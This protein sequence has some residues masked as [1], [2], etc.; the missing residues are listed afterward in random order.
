M[1][2]P[3]PSRD[4]SPSEAS[5]S[6]AGQPGRNTARRV[7]DQILS[8]TFGQA[9]SDQTSLEAFAPVAQRLGHQPFGL[10]PVV[11]ELVG[12]AIQRTFPK[13][14]FESPTGREMIRDVAQSLYADPRS[15]ERLKQIWSRLLE[16]LGGP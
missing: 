6:A 11:E 5:P 1:T 4:D 13:M 10:T 9:S 15:V 14:T 16:Q 2:Q 12:C 3:S 8:Q 7:L